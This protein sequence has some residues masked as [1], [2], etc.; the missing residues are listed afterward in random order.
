M[1]IYVGI[2][3]SLETLN[4]PWSLE[5]NRHAHRQCLTLKMKVL[6]VGLRF[7]IYKYLLNISY[8]IWWTRSLLHCINHDKITFVTTLTMIAKIQ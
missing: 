8:C 5:K 7:Y 1:Q 3:R 6:L 4:V 2:T